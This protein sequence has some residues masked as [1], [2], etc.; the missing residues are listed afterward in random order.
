MHGQPGS[1]KLVVLEIVDTRRRLLPLDRTIEQA[2][3]AYIFVREGYRQRAEFAIRGAPDP[4]ED[5][6]LD[7]EDEDWD[8]EEEL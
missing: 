1:R 6:G 2:P 3:D 5:I 4:D 8:D 7:F